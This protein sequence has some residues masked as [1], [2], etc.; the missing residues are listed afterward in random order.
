MTR[1]RASA[2]VAENAPVTPAALQRGLAEVLDRLEEQVGERLTLEPL[3]RLK[4][5]ADATTKVLLRTLSGQP[6]AVII[7]SRPVAPQLVARGTR[8]AEQIREMIGEPLGEAIIRPIG[9]GAIDGRSYVILPYCRDL[10]ARRPIRILQRLRIQ[11]RLFTWLRQANAKAAEAYEAGPTVTQS[12]A[13]ALEHLDRQRVLGAEIQAAI[14]RASRRLAS[15]RWQPRHTFDH[16]DLYLSNIMLPFRSQLVGRPRF[17]FVLIDWAGANPRG[18]GIYDLVRFARAVNLPSRSLRRELA[19]HGTA[20]QCELRDT[21][22]HLL[23]S[24]GR[25][26][27]H[28]EY[29]PE[30][31]FVQTANACWTT[32]NRAMLQGSGRDDI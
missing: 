18:F 19:G 15:G 8:L 9:H 26:H 17:P 3:G 30:P 29:F 21:P 28:L 23:A 6:A 31:R 16:N 25:L 4:E 24:L 27:M 11:G 5:V 1:Q 32:L 7:C 14:R 2:T 20:L 13:A 12:Y 10:S 22:G